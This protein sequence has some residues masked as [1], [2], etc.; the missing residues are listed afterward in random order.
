MTD[1]KYIDSAAYADDEVL[2]TFLLR[3]SRQ[4]LEAFRHQRPVVGTHAL[5]TFDT[6]TGSV[7]TPDAACMAELRGSFMVYPFWLAPGVTELRVNVEVRCTTTVTA[8]PYSQEATVR[9]AVLPMASFELGLRPRE[10]D[11]VEEDV[12]GNASVSVTKSL[13]L[14]TTN[15][16]RGWV[17]VWVGVVSGEGTETELQDSGGSG[18][19]CLTGYYSGYIVLDT[20]AS[21]VLGTLTGGADVPAWKVRIRDT[22]GKKSDNLGE[23]PPRQAIY[24]TDAGGGAGANRYNVYVYGAMTTDRAAQPPSASDSLW[25]TPLAEAEIHGV[26][27]K[28]QTVGDLPSVGAMIDA[29]Q[30]VSTRNL[31]PQI[32]DQ[33]REWLVRPR[34]YACG[35]HPKVDNT[36]WT[37]THP[38]SFTRP[39]VGLTTSYQTLAQCVT[40]GDDLYGRRDRSGTLTQ[41]RKTQVE[42]CAVLLVTL[43]TDDPGGPFGWNLTV[44]AY[45]TD[46]D[47]SS[48]AVGIEFPL[49]D[50]P[51]YRCPA[52][53]VLSTSQGAFPPL[54]RLVGFTS[55]NDPT[56]C[57][58]HAFASLLPVALW[59]S[60]QVG[61]CVY[62]WRVADTSTSDPR[63]LALQV[64]ATDSSA[65]LTSDGAAAEFAPNVHLLTWAVVSGA[66]LRQEPALADLGVTT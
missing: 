61:A 47:G 50:V 28:E 51:T 62:R 13:D 3:R 33:V 45:F 37:G 35:P 56:V 29:T 7:H 39:Y 59:S 10:G 24:I 1:F 40:G 52:S 64:K 49:V 12:T 63:L 57:Q 30:P 15:L 4:N 53:P 16:P 34:V 6:S 65:Q 8:S 38:H 17:T 36:D 32:R 20:A 11:F 31:S 21:N 14:D 9:A 60:P 58:R 26:T 25:Y 44:R 66:H 22:A 19:N 54:T 46:R 55:D 18:P 43:P 23:E 27:I 2:D 48:N 5:C 41:Y 42:V